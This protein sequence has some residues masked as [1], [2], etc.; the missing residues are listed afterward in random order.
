MLYTLTKKIFGWNGKGV[1]CPRRAS[2]AASAGNL[3]NLFKS[4]IFLGV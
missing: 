1:I 4:N 3:T 2:Q